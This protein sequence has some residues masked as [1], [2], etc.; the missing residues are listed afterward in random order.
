MCLKQKIY[1]RL[2]TECEQTLRTWRNNVFLAICFNFRDC[3]WLHDV[4]GV[5]IIFPLPL[6]FLQTDECWVP[7]ATYVLV[8]GYITFIPDL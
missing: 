5:R 3:S 8:I 1:S 2:R 4:K 6:S 7:T